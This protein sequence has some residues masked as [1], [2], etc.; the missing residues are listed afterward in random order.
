MKP[1][2]LVK[3]EDSH[4]QHGADLPEKPVKQSPGPADGGGEDQIHIRQGE[5][6]PPLG[7]PIPYHVEEDE[8]EERGGHG[9]HLPGVSV[10][11]WGRAALTA[12]HGQDEEGHQEHH[13]DQPCRLAEQVANGV[14]QPGEGEVKQGM[15]HDSLPPSVMAKKRS[16]RLWACSSS[17][18]LYW[19]AAKR[20]C[21]MMWVTSQ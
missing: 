5:D 7:K 15:H 20:P 12:S 14:F 4:Q 19:V 13:V 11:L 21:I 17:G 10:G 2:V 3:E 6:G 16:S 18:R 1:A 9:Y 8:Q